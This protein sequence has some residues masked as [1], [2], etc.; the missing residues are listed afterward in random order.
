MKQSRRRY[1]TWLAALGLLS[2]C[3]TASVDPPLAPPKFEIAPAAPGALG[4]KAAGTDAAPAPPDE[5]AN[6]WQSEVEESPHGNPGDGKPEEE[7]GN[8]KVPDQDAGGLPL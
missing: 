6:P 8:P 4:A 7:K 1:A 3:E 2:A 5:E